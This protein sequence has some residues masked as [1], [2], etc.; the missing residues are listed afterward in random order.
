MTNPIW[1][2][3]FVVRIKHSVVDDDDHHHHHHHYNYIMREDRELHHHR[4][5]H[6]NTQE[7][8]VGSGPGSPNPIIIM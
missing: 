1:K 3:L 8:D 2:N 6:H 7:H 5:H 4:H